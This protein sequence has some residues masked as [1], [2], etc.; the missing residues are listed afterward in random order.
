MINYLIMPRVLKIKYLTSFGR[1][2]SKK[3]IL[4]KTKNTKLEYWTN[5]N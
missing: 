3:S 4:K 2:G 1:E 5:L